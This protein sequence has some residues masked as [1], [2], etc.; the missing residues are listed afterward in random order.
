MLVVLALASTAGAQTNDSGALTLTARVSG[1]VDIASGGAV[2]LT[3]AQGGGV[4]GNTAKGNKLTGVTISLG[5]LSPANPNDVVRA[6]VPLRLRSN[7]AYTLSVS[8]PGFSNADPLALQSSDVGFGIGNIQRS[9]SGVNTQGTDTPTAATFGDP[10]TGSDADGSSPRWDFPATKSLSYF[11][12]SRPVLTGARI[13]NVV[14]ASHVG[15]LTLDAY[16]VVKPQ[17][18]TPGD[19]TTTVSFTISTP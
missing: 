17:F 8:S 2:T 11:S 15:G 7:I 19:F 6:V 13:M 10:W 18:F 1:Y 5:D 14:P 3:G 4:T 9:D 12:S 16:F